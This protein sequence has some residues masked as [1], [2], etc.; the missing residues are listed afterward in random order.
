[1]RKRTTKL[2][3]FMASMFIFGVCAGFAL[4]GCLAPPKPLMVVAE[5]KPSEPSYMGPKDE[6]QDGEVEAIARTLAGEC[7]DDK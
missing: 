7:Y 6:F 2:V 4:T 3:I 1:M 5:A